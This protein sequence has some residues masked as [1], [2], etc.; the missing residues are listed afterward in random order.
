MPKAKKVN[1]KVKKDNIL[2]LILTILFIGLVVWLVTM[3][4]DIFKTKTTVKETKIVDEV[5]DYGYYLTDNNSEY[6]KTLYE[7]LKKVLNADEL[8]DEKYAECIAKLFTADFY[9]LN[10]KLSK[11]DVGGTQFVVSEYKDTFVKSANSY[12]G[13]Y[14]Y[15]E[16]DLYDERTQ[17][18]P[19]VKSVD[20][21]STKVTSY[22]YEKINDTN[23]YIVTL[24]VTYEKDLGYPKTVTVTVAHNNNRIEV[25]EV[26]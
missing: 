7:E 12:G 22:K 19:I 15:V 2:I 8:N 16:S 6:F 20:V 21:V 10:S 23:A 13:I 17:E 18:L 1:R 11:S 9:D 25:V 4:K 5:K 3:A 24:N 14:Y 26:K